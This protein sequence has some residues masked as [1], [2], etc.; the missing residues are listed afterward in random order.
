MI[1]P[2]VLVG[3][4]LMLAFSTSIQ[5]VGW[6]AMRGAQTAWDAQLGFYLADAAI[7][8]AIGEWAPDS[9]ARTPI[10]TALVIESTTSRGWRTRRSIVRTAALTAVVHAVAQRSW[11]TSLDPTQIP[12]GALGD[13]TRIRRTT[14]RVV[15]LDPPPI[16]VLAAATFLGNATLQSA[17][18][19]GRDQPQFYDP[20][21]DDCGA[22]RDSASI[23]GVAAGMLNVDGMTTLHGAAVTLAADVLA[24]AGSRFDSAFALVQARANTITPSAFATVPVL[25]DWSAAVM[26][27]AGVVTLEGSSRHVGLLAVDGDLVIHGA[28]RVDGVLLVRGAL[29]TSVG[30]LDVHG[31]LIVRDAAGNGSTLGNGGLVMYTPCLVGR[32]LVAVARPR[33]A[34]FDVWNSP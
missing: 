24:R 9:I 21:L 8:E 23:D 33:A 25:A 1:L 29:D 16:P 14:T 12:L 22:L 10:G 17:F 27:G 7:A 26:H 6:R 31:A 18:A 13:A 15:R 5:Q 28:L 30:A 3:I 2:L 4:L 32:A 20:R 34:P 19:D 11:S